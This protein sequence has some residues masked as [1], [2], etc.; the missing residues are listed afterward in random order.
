VATLVPDE[1]C[2]VLFGIKNLRV[3]IKNETAIHPGP[4]LPPSGDGPPL[5]ALSEQYVH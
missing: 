5:L 4:V 3:E 2:L 1:I